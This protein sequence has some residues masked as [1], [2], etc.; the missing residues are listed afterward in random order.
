MTLMPDNADFDVLR[1][2]ELLA[3]PSSLSL[4]AL[5]DKLPKSSVS[6]RVGARYAFVIQ[7]IAKQTGMSQSALIERLLSSAVET[8]VRH[9][10][11][12]G[13]EDDQPIPLLDHPAAP[14]AR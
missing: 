10:E 12:P 7:V 4:D 2:L 11:V 14:E 8:M 3:E 5:I 6:A 1:E 13:L 9:R